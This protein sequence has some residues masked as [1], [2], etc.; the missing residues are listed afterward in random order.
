MSP[1]QARSSLSQT[2]HSLFAAQA[3][4]TPSKVAIVLGEEELSYEELDLRSNQLAHHL[5]ARGIRRGD[6]V[7]LC[8]ERSLDLVV[9][10]L[11][12]VKAGAGYLPLELR[13]P[14][15]RLAHILA[16][17]QAPVVLT[18]S[19]TRDALPTHAGSTICLD[20]HARELA[21]EPT[22]APPPVG[23]G[24]DVAYVLYTSGSTGNPKG[25]VTEHRSVPGLVK[26]VSYASLGP[27]TT[28]VQLGPIG[29]DASTLEIWGVLLNGGRCVLYPDVGPTVAG[30]RDV[31]RR[32]DV[33]T[34]VVTTALFNVVAE[35]APDVFA[36][37]RELLIGGEAHSVAHVRRALAVLPD[38]R[39]VNVYGPT[40]TTTFASSFEIPRHLPATARSVPIG[41]AIDNARLHVLDAAWR[42]VEPGATG[43][44]YIGGSGLARGYLGHPGL[45][46]ERFVP[47]QFGSP[48]DRLYRTGDLVR[49]LPGGEL[50]FIGRA[51]DQL[52]IRGFRVEP[53]E[54]ELA[55]MAE[56][57]VQAVS[58]VAAGPPEGKV[59]VAF[60][61]AASDGARPGPEFGAELARRLER[62]LPAFMVP[63]RWVDVEALPL[64]PVGKVDRQALRRRA[65]EEIAAGRDL[66]AGPR[67]ARRAAAPETATEIAL[68]EM[69]TELLHVGAVGREDGFVELG[70]DSLSALS[71]V[72]RIEQVFGVAISLDEFFEAESLAALASVVDERSGAAEPRSAHV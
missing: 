57:E 2:V 15:Q 23:G 37:L 44:L 71:L 22:S 49:E 42:P 51:D 40:E 4:E 67:G 14:P 61:R 3:R 18:D 13:F 21:A 35:Q 48:G 53:T 7:G 12:I 55:L 27:D 17:T 39:V 33:T 46:A 65:E 8:L 34:M 68:A 26:D 25:V 30:I 36:P 38:T 72:E 43:E 66:P 47:D 24:H 5:L 19:T 63:S 69:W 9:A 28:L 29:F 56:P 31:I 41:R 54:V 62:R 58:V 20:D 10:M 11:A 70:G 32:H 64:N 1:A 60:V 45:T 59:L 52:K 50:D 16:E 6:L